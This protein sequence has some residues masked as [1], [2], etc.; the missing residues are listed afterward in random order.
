MEWFLVKLKPEYIECV[1][2]LLQAGYAPYNFYFDKPFTRDELL[3]MP[4]LP[5][6]ETNR[7][8]VWLKDSQDVEKLRP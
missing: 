5:T 2:N 8:I 6:D 4:S 3:A 7:D 1:D